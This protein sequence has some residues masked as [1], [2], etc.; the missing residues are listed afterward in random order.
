MDINPLLNSAVRL[1]HQLQAAD[2]ELAA[3]VRDARG[4]LVGRR[5]PRRRLLSAPAPTGRLTEPSPAVA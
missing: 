5:R 4:R 1:D 3:Q 2:A